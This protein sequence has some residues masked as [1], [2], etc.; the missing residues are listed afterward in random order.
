MQQ[1]GVRRQHVKKW[2]K[3]EDSIVYG[4]LKAE[5]LEAANNA[6]SILASMLNVKP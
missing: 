6:G 2:D 4:I 5:W 1:E 3:C